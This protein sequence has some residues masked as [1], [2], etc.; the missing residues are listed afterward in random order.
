[1]Y[2]FKSLTGSQPY[3]LSTM[4]IALSSVIAVSI[5]YLTTKTIFS[6]TPLWFVPVAG[7]VY[8]V[9]YIL[10]IFATRGL[11]DEDL[12]IVEAIEHKAGIEAPLIKE[13]LEKAV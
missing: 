11:D 5:T 3:K 8:A 10:M 13:I 4:K 1:M 7:S 12:M 9:V 6:T 2:N